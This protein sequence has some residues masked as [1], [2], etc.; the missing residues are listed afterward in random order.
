MPVE[1]VSHIAGNLVSDPSRLR[2]EARH[3]GQTTLIE[4]HCAPEDAGQLI[5]RG[6]RVI[7][8]IRTL[9]RAA[10]DGQQRVD[11][12]LVDEAVAETFIDDIDEAQG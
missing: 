1:L 8:S 3:D 2:V 7:N 12:T 4:I 11:V 9:A 6:G 5:G 10:A